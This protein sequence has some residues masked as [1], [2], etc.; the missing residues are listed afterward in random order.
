MYN[1]QRVEMGT[2][3]E[4]VDEKNIDQQKE[5]LENEMYEDGRGT[6]RLRKQGGNEGEAVERKKEEEV[7]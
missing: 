2:K 4:K 1:K 5:S 6:Y 7:H 3:E